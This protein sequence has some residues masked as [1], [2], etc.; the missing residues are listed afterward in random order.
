MTGYRPMSILVR[1]EETAEAGR[2]LG[3]GGSHN[4]HIGADAKDDIVA[5]V[6]EL[7]IRFRK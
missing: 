3:F 4:S 1:R 5:N 7:G 2:E 6:A